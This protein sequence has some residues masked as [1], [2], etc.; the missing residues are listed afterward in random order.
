MNPAA[1]L[2]VLPTRAEGAG[3]VA[4]ATRVVAIGVVVAVIS[5]AGTSGEIEA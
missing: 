5:A 1:I 4:E 2:G 3:L